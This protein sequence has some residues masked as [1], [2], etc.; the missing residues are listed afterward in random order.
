MTEI[1]K[2]LLKIACV[3]AYAVWIRCLVGNPCQS[4]K[5]VYEA[6][7]N[8]RPGDWVLEVSA[9]RWRNPEDAL[10]KL[11][12]V[13]EEPVRPAEPEYGET[14]APTETI[15]YIETLDGREYRWYNCHFIRV[16]ADWDELR[17]VEDGRETN[18]A[19][20]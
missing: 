16:F 12:R 8:P 3:S 15:Y 7:A 4:T 14:E 6:V 20:Q 5:W 19:R 18:V 17:A 2:Q 10:G 11:I 9:G 13:A 1:E